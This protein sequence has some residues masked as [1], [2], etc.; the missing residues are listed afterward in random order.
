MK[1]LILKLQQIYFPFLV[2]AFC[3]IA[4]YSFLNWLFVIKTEWI[5][6]NETWMNIGIPFALP[7]IPMLIWLRPRIKLLKLESTA[8]KDWHDFYFFLAGMAIV[9]PTAMAQN[10]LSTATG[11]L[12]KLDKIEQVISQPKTHY[13]TF[14][15]LK[16]DKIHASVYRTA[17]VTGRHSEGLDYK[18]F[19]ACPIYH[20]PITDSVNADNYYLM[21]GKRVLTLVNGKFIKVSELNRI[22]EKDI[23]SSDVIDSVY[24]RA[25][26]GDNAKSGAYLISTNKSLGE[27][28]FTA[29]QVNDTAP[30]AWLA[31]EY[32][33]NISN[34]ISDVEKDNEWKS[35]WNNS[36]RDFVLKDLTKCEYFERLRNNDLRKGAMEAINNSRLK[37]SYDKP[38][39]LNAINKPY[40][41]RNGNALPWVFGSFAIGA[42]VWLIMILIPAYKPAR[43]ISKKR[44][45]TASR[46]MWRD[47]LVP[48][49][50][51]AGFYVT[52]IIIN[53]NVLVFVVMV[54]AGLGFMSFDAEDLL[55]WGANYRPY[56]EDGQWWRLL[57]STFLHGGV[58][59]IVMNMFSLMFIGA[60][61]EP[62]IG[63][64]RYILAYLI[65]GIAA[66]LASMYWHTVVGVGASG[67]IF[68]LYGVFGA[69]LTTP[70]FTKEAKK[71]LGKTIGIFVGYNLLFGLTGGIDNAAHIGG[72]LSGVLI[73][74]IYYFSLKANIAE[75]KTVT[76]NDV[77]EV[78]E[79]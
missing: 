56:N 65:T 5:E 53:I 57:S 70:I 38:I 60:L 36:Y 11:S 69:L 68:G 45:K 39:I 30:E 75:T 21:E 8:G 14:R 25:N 20:K 76:G 66:S 42:G 18:I 6:L 59:H 74:Y 41:Q 62:L 17:E 46:R 35:F 61:F 4:G 22:G 58:I 40:D 49:I 34:K 47:V 9:I 23:H 79:P 55:T 72:L 37:E 7:W 67:A 12:T 15:S 50:P 51:R 24:A 54:I 32:N 26:F 48:F 33:L 27:L 16:V 3:C 71:E 28:G 43:A 44:K 64:K 78:P 73:G 77:N 1:N 2:I 10:Y 52:P 31:V 63:Y 19:F 29:K 13:Y